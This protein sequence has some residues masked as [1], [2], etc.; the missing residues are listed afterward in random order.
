[1]LGWCWIRLR[2]CQPSPAAQRGLSPDGRA[3]MGAGWVAYHD[4]AVG[5]MN[6]AL[7]AIAV[8]TATSMLDRAA[9]VS[10]FASVSEGV[11]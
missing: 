4:N 9:P 10:T 6:G 11:L 8:V 3:L 1:M 5:W 2:L 7:R